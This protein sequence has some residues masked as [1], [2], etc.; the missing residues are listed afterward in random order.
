MKGFVRETLKELN[1][2][3]TLPAV[4][5]LLKDRSVVE[6]FCVIISKEGEDYSEK[7]Q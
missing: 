1:Y 2:E 6:K 7:N 5:R 4:R 3:V